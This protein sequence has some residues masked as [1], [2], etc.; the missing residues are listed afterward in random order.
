MSFRNKIWWKK[1]FGQGVGF[2]LLVSSFT[3][4]EDPWVVNLFIG[5]CGWGLFTMGLKAE[6]QEWF[7]EWSKRP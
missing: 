5:A 3:H 1:S 7:A 6:V 2:A 4:K